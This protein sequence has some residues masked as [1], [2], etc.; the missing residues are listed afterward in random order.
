MAL[1]PESTFTLGA[2]SMS[3]TL[4]AKTTVLTFKLDTNSLSWC[5]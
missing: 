2:K 4:Y 5:M 1:Y 3:I